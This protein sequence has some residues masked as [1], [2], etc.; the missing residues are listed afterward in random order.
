M[1]FLA[2]TP[3][4]QSGKAKETDKDELNTF[5]NSV[6]VDLVRILRLNYYLIGEY[7]Y[8]VIVPSAED[9]KLL[10]PYINEPQKFDL[11]NSSYLAEEI[12]K[13]K[14]SGMNP[15]LI[16]AMEIDYAKKKFSSEEEIKDYV[17]L[18]L[19]LDPFPGITDGDKMSRL[20]NGGIDKISYI[21]SSNIAGF[22]RRAIEEFDTKEKNFCSEEF[23]VQIKVLEKYA[24]EVDKKNSLA[25][26]VMGEIDPEKSKAA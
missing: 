25:A 6:A 9:R 19:G 22:V 4:N 5:V 23:E 26:Q 2:D 21:V 3:L 15:V 12:A 17:D 16:T 1:E 11:L 10:I 8:R 14:N 7:R 13:A 18:V 20:Q 24:T